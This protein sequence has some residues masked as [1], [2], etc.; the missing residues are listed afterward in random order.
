MLVYFWDLHIF[1][2]KKKKNTTTGNL[3]FE[4]LLRII[5]DFFLRVVE[6][7]FLVPLALCL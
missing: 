6:G 3:E 4:F 5:I 1:V 2:L 7:S